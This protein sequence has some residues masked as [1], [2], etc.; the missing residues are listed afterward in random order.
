MKLEKS[1][2]LFS[3]LKDALED[4]I[5]DRDKYFTLCETYRATLTP[6]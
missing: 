6:R 1:T 4:L 2:F 5:K 3:A